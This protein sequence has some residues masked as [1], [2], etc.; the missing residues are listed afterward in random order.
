MRLCIKQEPSGDAAALFLSFYAP[1][2]DIERL[3][4]LSPIT[5]NCFNCDR[6]SNEPDVRSTAS[7]PEPEAIDGFLLFGR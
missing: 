3:M 6:D 5:K 4:S 7:G 2:D 1:G